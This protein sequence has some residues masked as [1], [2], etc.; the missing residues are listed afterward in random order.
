M[1]ASVAS[2][3]MRHKACANA[4]KASASSLEQKRNLHDLMLRKKT[5]QPFTRQGAGGRSTSNGHV[6]TVF[7][8]TGFLG[9]YVVNRLAQQ[10]TQ[11]VIAHR[12]P[13]EA[14]PL[15]VT[16]DLGQIVPLEVDLKDRE[17]INEVVRH[18]DIVYNLI[19]RDYETKNYTFDQVHVDG[20]RAIAEACAENDV[21]RLVHVSALNANEDS[22]SGF[23]RSKARGEKAVREVVPGATIVRPGTMYGQEDRFLNRIGT[24][25]GWQFWVNESKAKIR[26]VYAIDVAQAMEIFLTAETTIGKTYEF[27]GPKEYTYEQIF[28][29]AREISKKPLPTYNV[30][31]SIAKLAANIVDKLPYNQMICPD[32]IERMTLD[33][34]PTPGALTFADL[35]IEPTDLDAI[36]IQFLRRF[37]STA[38]FDLPYEKGD[39]QVKKGVYHV[40]D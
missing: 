23:L 2:K 22:T 17:S 3:Q 1:L 13:D 19:G 32:L 5:G 37:R 34:K 14:R 28:E 6:A 27:Y 8:C 7:G 35:Y 26:P 33:D 38:I 31:T 36:A 15:K 24:G 4:I 18:S 21:A 9:R 39:G 11:V 40:I 12:D 10:G 16:G 20:A 30:P 25:E 29:L